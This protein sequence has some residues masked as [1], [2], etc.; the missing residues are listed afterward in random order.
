MRRDRVLIRAIT[1][2]GMLVSLSTGE[3]LRKAR[4]EESAPFEELE[5]E[6]FNALVSAVTLRRRAP[7]LTALLR[8]TRSL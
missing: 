4:R 1:V 2:D 6:P 7:K 5:D 3:T 8:E